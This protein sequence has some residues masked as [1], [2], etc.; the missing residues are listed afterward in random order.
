M[1]TGRGQRATVQLADGSRVVLGVDSRIR[2]P[3][4]FGKQGREID[5]VGEAYFDVV[6]DARVPFRV[7]TPHGVSEDVGTRFAVRAYAGES[8]A[9]VVVE[10]GFVAVGHGVTLGAG[11]LARVTRQAAPHV[12][13]GAPV[14]RLLAWT[15]GQLNFVN[16]PLR[17]VVA[18]LRRWYDVTV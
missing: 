9:R 2:Y 1:A 5:L 13:H 16:T 15:H 10:E 17:E 7:R 4:G 18:D 8:S 3:R 14:A 12:V 11:D 6:H